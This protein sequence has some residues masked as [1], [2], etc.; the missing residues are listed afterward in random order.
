MPVLPA[1]A[2]NPSAS[3]SHQTSAETVYLDNLAT[4]AVDPRV[5]E[6]MLPFFSEHFGNAASKTHAFGLVA[7]EALET[8]REQ[9]A[10]LVGAPSSQDVIFTSGATEANNLAIKGVVEFRGARPCHV[11]TC[12][13]EHRAVLDCCRSLEKKGVRLTYL[14]VDTDGRIDPDQLR[15]AIGEETVLISIMA[16]NNEIGTVQPLAAIGLIAREK[17]VLWHCDAAQAAGK[18][19]LDVEDLG[20]DLLSISAH[21]MYGPKGQGALFARR[22]HPRVRMAPQLE[23]GGQERGLRSGTVNVPGAVG[24]GK[25]CETC[26]AEMKAGEAER[27]RAMRDRLY[28]GLLAGLQTEVSLNGHVE[29][30]LPGCLNVSLHD[31]DGAALMVALRDIALSSGAACTSGSSE[32]SHVLRAIGRDDTLAFGS[33]RFGVGR[34]NTAGEMDLAAHRVIAEATRLRGQV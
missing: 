12:V 24:L 3:E 17:E 27:V 29:Y 26:A 8:A 14:P 1:A 18:I 7:A 33:L 32:P 2:A 23:G 30:R 15:D 20:V 19:P 31:I 13:T 16:A 6:A 34:F 5:L 28:E 10:R 25:A 22:K 9:V 4:S 11:V 21:K